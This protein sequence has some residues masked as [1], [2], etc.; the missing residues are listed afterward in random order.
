MKFSE[1]VT[2]LRKIS[3]GEGQLIKNYANKHIEPSDKF[4]QGAAQPR[5]ES[6]KETFAFGHGEIKLT[7]TS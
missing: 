7:S 3:S 6:A 5:R 1:G 4:S 2:Q